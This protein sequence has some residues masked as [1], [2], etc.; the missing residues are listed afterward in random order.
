MLLTGL[1]PVRCIHREILS[2]SVNSAIRGSSKQFTA[3]YALE[4]DGISSIL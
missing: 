4:N 3:V 1:E 2:F